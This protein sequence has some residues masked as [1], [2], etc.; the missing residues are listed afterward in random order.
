MQTHI[1][2]FLSTFLLLFPTNHLLQHLLHDASTR[3]F[4]M[5]AVLNAVITYLVW[6]DLVSVVMDPLSSLVQ[7]PTCHAP[8]PMTVG[9][10][11]FHTVMFSKRMSVSDWIHHIVGNFVVVAMTVLFPTGRMS[12]ASAFFICGLPGGVDYVMLV[13]IKLGLMQP[14]TEKRINSHLNTLVRLPGTLFLASVSWVCLVNG[15][16]MVPAWAVLVQIGINVWNA[17]FYQYRVVYNYAR[18]KHS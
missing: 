8:L 16:V 2:I 9:L 17:G 13:G 14:L 11:M 1:Q 3:Y 18:I 7:P 5:H 12:N 6:N 4:L 10:H 15:Q